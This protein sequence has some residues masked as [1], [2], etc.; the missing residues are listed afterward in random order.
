MCPAAPARPG[1]DSC[2]VQQSEF[3]MAEANPEKTAL[4]RTVLY[5]THGAAGA[6]MVNFGGWEMPL[7]YPTGAV[8]EHMA[9]LTGAGL[10]DTSHMSAIQAEG[11]RTREF[12]NYA[13][14]KEIG[15]LR[16]GRAAYGIVLDDSGFAVDDGIVY[17][18]EETRFV[19]VVNAGMGGKVI[20]HM[21]SLPGGGELAWTDLAGTY[22]KLDIQGPASFGVLRQ[23]V[24][25]ADAVFAKFPYFSFQG[26]FDFAR[27]EVTLSD[28]TPVVLSRTGY[29]GELGFE[30]FV[31]AAKATTLWSM[32]LEAG[33]ELPVLP[34]GLAARDSLRAGA[35]LPLSHQDIGPWPF[36][37]N[38]WSFALPYGEDG[39]FTKNFHGRDALDAKT[40]DHTLAYVGYDPR[41]VETHDAI[42]LHGG[43]DI[44]TV[45]TSVAD[46]GIGRVE[47]RVAGLNSP[48]IP[49]DWRPR[50]LVCGFIKVREYVEPGTEV[51]L[52]D[53]RREI[54]VVIHTDIRPGRTARRALS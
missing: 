28:G 3:A 23:C 14:T 42:V 30:L 11:A 7:W 49:R 2:H 5:A 48:D 36:I 8:K 53:S 51:I 6:T 35:V 41:K 54:K 19:L 29:T 46:M 9:V 39:T 44:G 1:I 10:F 32:L 22:A 12:L 17:P 15:N 20:A 47:N 31:P 26:D 38:P 40:A 45:L 25:N 37:N 50:G 4:Q 52:K 18:L 34:C 43:K 21:R 33:K 24:A 13:L 27:S 16:I